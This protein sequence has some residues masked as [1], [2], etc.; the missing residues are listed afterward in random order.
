MA[1]GS[2][3]PLITAPILCSNLAKDEVNLVLRVLQAGGAVDGV[4]QNV[5]GEA[6]PQGVGG[7]LAGLCGVR[8]AH[9]G[10]PLLHGALFGQDQHQTRAPED[11][12]TDKGKESGESA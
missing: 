5:P 3:L 1:K 11:H 4:F 2:H 12:G 9:H 10:P 8:G 7:H 6:G